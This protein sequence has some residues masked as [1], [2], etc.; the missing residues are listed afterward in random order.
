MSIFPTK[1]INESVEAD[2]VEE[3]GAHH[4]VPILTQNFTFLILKPEVV[5]P[6]CFL[7]VKSTRCLTNEKILCK[8]QDYVIQNTQY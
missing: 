7:A 3:S 5:T 2:V 8:T 6:Q 4:I 1:I